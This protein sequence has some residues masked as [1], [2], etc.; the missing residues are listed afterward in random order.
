MNDIVFNPNIDLAIENEKISDKEHPV[1]LFRVSVKSLYVEITTENYLTMSMKFDVIGKDIRVE[2]YRQFIEQKHHNYYELAYDAIHDLF[3][4]VGVDES[5][6][7]VAQKPFDLDTFN[8]E[9]ENTIGKELIILIC[10]VVMQKH[11]L[12]GTY[13]RL[14][15]AYFVNGLSVEEQRIHEIAPYHIFKEAEMST[16]QVLGSF[17]KYWVEQGEDPYQKIPKQNKDL[18]LLERE[19]KDDYEKYNKRKQGK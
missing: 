2:L 1:G 19:F 18:S 16:P 14:D 11:N 4:I 5:M 6:S 10:N 13:S 3:E 12:Y 8:E 9:L 7:R 17:R 15:A